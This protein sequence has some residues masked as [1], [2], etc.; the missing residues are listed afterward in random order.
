MAFIRSG[1]A[2]LRTDAGYC[3]VVALIVAAAAGPLGSALG[4]P[5][6]LLLGAAAVTALWALLLAVAAARRPVRGVLGGVLVVNVVAAAGIAALG[7]TRPPD[8]LSLLLFAVAAEV[9][10]FAAWQGAL[11]PAAGQASR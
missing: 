9:A 2:C 11:L 5:V 6:P 3:A 10:A 7:A 1:P 4:L 8:A